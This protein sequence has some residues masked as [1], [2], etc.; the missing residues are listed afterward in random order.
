MRVKLPTFFPAAYVTNAVT[1]R[2][3]RGAAGEKPMHGRHAMLGKEEGGLQRNMG[4]L[5]GLFATYL[6]RKRLR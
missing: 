1:E 2:R 5:H 6:C 3:D 4:L